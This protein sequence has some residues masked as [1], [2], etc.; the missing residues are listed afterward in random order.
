MVNV[1][2]NIRV[3]H[4]KSKASF[5][6]ETRTKYSTVLVTHGP[7]F[8][9][10][11]ATPN[12]IPPFRAPEVVFFGAS[13]VGKSTLIN[14]LCR[15][16]SLA[17]TSKSPG[18][19][20]LLN[21]FAVPSPR[22]V[23]RNRSELTLVDVPGYGFAALPP[24]VR[25]NWE[26]LLLAYLASRRSLLRPYVLLDARRGVRDHDRSMVELLKG[27]DLVPTFVL[28]KMDKLTKAETEAIL[29]AVRTDLP[30]CAECAILS[31]SSKSREGLDTLRAHL[32]S[33]E[34]GA[35]ADA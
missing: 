23:G 27:H 18:C 5:L 20:R 21:F 24:S 10:S 16:K 1:R 3:Q 19:T 6:K 30:G 14:A 25:Q 13:N 7:R 26:A 33:T 29:P 34:E 8:L 17:K 35:F 11:V 22:E 4:R 28:T 31:T 12:R 9:F 15:Q 32:F 2:K